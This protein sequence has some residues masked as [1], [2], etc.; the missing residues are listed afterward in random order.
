V[1]GV[2]GWTGTQGVTGWTGSQGPT[3][4]QGSTGWTGATGWTGSQG[5]TGF[6]G[7]QGATGWTGAQGSTGWTGSTGAGFGATGWTGSTGAQGLAGNP[8][9]ISSTA[10]TAQVNVAYI[11]NSWFFSSNVLISGTTLTS[12]IVTVTSLAKLPYVLITGCNTTIPLTTLSYGTTYI[13]SNVS[14]TP[15]FTYTTLN[16]P[17]Y[18]YVKNSHTTNISISVSNIGVANYFPTGPANCNLFAAASNWTRNS[19]LVILYAS[20]ETSWFL[21]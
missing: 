18:I 8:G 5:A 10:N 1:Q 15:V 12:P 4:A 17:F 13:L 21:Y 19:A 7:T 20:N 14:F 16:Y 2:T 11:N 9:N 6:T 3:G